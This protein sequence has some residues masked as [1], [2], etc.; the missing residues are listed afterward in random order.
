MIC[1]FSR[2]VPELLRHSDR[3]DV[4]DLIEE[5]ELKA[6]HRPRVVERDDAPARKI[7]ASSSGAPLRT[8]LLA[9]RKP[10]TD[11][12][13]VD[14]LDIGGDLRFEGDLDDEDEALLDGAG[15]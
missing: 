2:M 7:E 1:S 15:F 14:D 6:A 4:L 12:W 13:E 5:E 8:Q 9:L 11:L 3:T 10:A